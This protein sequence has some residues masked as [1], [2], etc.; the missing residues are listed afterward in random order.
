MH[1]HQPEERPKF[2]DRVRDDGETIRGA[3]EP[4]VEERIHIRARVKRL[5][6]ERDVNRQLMVSDFAIDPTPHDLDLVPS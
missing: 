2:H 6:A 3:D 1:G 5:V 4:C